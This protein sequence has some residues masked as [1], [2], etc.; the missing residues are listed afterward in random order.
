MSKVIAVCISEKKRTV[1]HEVN[2]I[3]CI[4]DYGIEH[5]AHAGK[6]HRQVSLMALKDI[7]DFQSGYPS[8]SYGVYAENILIDDLNLR[9]LPI[10]SQIII[11]DVIL[12]V[13]QIGKECHSGC[14]IQKKT[15]K[16]VM[17]QIGVFTKV[18]HGGI[19]RPNDEVKLKVKECWSN[20]LPFLE[21][22]KNP[23]I[24]IVGAGALGQQVAMQLVRLGL[25]HLKI[26]D[27]D[28]FDWSNCNRQLYANQHTI[29][30]KKIDV[31]KKEVLLINSS[32][33]I[34][35]YDGY[36]NEENASEIMKK[37]DILVDCVD[38]IPTKCF[39]EKICEQLQVPMI[40]G[41]VN[42]WHGQVATIL[43]GMKILET[44]YQK[45]K[46]QSESA[47]VFSVGIVASIQVREIIKLMNQQEIKK[48]V[49]FIDCFNQEISKV[50]M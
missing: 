35:V 29:Q 32:S 10:G 4:E 44:L 7:D 46:N 2:E 37:I 21:I 16:C 48:E 30:Q 14:E 1:K 18:I 34:D 26:V 39:C 24:L 23:N 28:C 45:Q 36:F 19:I 43:P 8:S 40:H 11:H 13:T 17:P 3:H 41:A 33:E 38:S 12:E 22:K 9:F 31:L 50:E 42:G 25:T 27:G 49:I 5:D 20:N 47:L 15:G 6:W